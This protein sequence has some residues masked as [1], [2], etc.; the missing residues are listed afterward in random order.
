MTGCYEMV[1]TV[2]APPFWTEEDEEEEEEDGS[3]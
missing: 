2:S 3:D 1:D